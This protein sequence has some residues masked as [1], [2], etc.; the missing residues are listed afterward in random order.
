MLDAVGRNKDPPNSRP[1]DELVQRESPSKVMNKWCEK[2]GAPLR[3]KSVDFSSPKQL[4]VLGSEPT[5]KGRM[6]GS[7][8]AASEEDIPL[9]PVNQPPSIDWYVKRKN[10]KKTLHKKQDELIAG[11]SDWATTPEAFKSGEKIRIN[12]I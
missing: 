1:F 9:I 5:K 4:Q 10:T 3:I 7:A 8:S 2:F 12:A 6:L 11:K